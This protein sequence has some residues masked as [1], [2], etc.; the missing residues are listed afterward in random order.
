MGYLG[1]WREGGLDLRDC[2]ISE[3]IEPVEAVE[4]VMSTGRPCSSVHAVIHP[5]Q[6][7]PVG[8]ATRVCV[9]PF[10]PSRLVNNSAKPAVPSP[11][12]AEFL[13]FWKDFGLSLFG[14]GGHI[15]ISRCCSP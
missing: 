7:G 8:A 10:H 11:A 3:P 13:V 2:A 14:T 12:A 4:P 1:G 6:R 5:A 9:E 15:G